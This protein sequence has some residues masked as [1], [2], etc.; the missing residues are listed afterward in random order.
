MLVGVERLWFSFFEGRLQTMSLWSTAR[1][2]LPGFRRSVA[3]EVESLEEGSRLPVTDTVKGQLLNYFAGMEEASL[4]GF[5]F[6]RRWS[7]FPE[8]KYDLLIYDAG[9]RLRYQGRVF[10]SSAHFWTA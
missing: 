5:T 1:A 6:E 9:G 10:A 7:D 3:D 2:K 8:A 4:E